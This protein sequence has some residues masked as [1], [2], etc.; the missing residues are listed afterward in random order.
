MDQAELQALIL[1]RI[2]AG[3]LPVK[4]PDLEWAGYG[5][6]KACDACGRPIESG[7]VEYELEFPAAVSPQPLRFHL[8]CL[9]IWKALCGKA[10]R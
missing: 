6:G 9:R 7:A 3:V 10:R 1:R 5:T 2:E 8:G 4:P